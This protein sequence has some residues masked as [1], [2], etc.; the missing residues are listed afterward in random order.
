MPKPEQLVHNIHGDPSCAAVR[1]GRCHCP[2]AP[3]ATAMRISYEAIYQGAAR[4][5]VEKAHK[6]AIRT[7]A[8]IRDIGVLLR[9]L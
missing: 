8:E 4:M 2:R 5:G 1:G 7:A 9:R 6:Q 3:R